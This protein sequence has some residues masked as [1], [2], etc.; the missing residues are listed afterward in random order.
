MLATIVSTGVFAQKI[1]SVAPDFRPPNPD[2]AY[3]KTLLADV[4]R[5]GWRHV[6]VMGYMDQ[7]WDDI[8]T[9]T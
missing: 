6:H 1:K 4:T 7:E 3:D 8:P 9:D 5:V 2:S